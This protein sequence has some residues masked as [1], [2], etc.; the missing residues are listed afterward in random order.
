MG[1]TGDKSSSQVFGLKKILPKLRP[2]CVQRVMYK[3][4]V[5]LP[6]AK[7]PI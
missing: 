7:T 2:R 1:K 3:Q 6:A 4:M 5:G